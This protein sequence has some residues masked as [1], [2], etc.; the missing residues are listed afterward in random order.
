M[1]ADKTKRSLMW[2]IL[3]VLAC[4]ILLGVISCAGDQVL[5]GYNNAEVPTEYA[6]PE[7]KTLVDLLTP[8]LVWI[9]LLASGLIF[10]WRMEKR[11]AVETNDS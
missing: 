5:K 9:G 11:R 2:L 3:A 6:P 7:P 1:M 10:F 4:C 8:W